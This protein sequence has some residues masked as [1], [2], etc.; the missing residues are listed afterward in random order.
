MTLIEELKLRDSFYQA[1]S[2]ELEQYLEQAPRTF[3]LGVDPTAD[4]LQVG[5]WATLNIALHLMNRGHKMILVIGG[6]TGMIG[7]PSGKS[8]ERNLLDIETLQKN[9]TLWPSAV[10]DVLNARTL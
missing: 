6:A 3:Y 9:E 10:D 7:D 4:S 2:E 8:E 5:N 1:S